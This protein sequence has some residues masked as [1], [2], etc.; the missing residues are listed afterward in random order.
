MSGDAVTIEMSQEG[1]IVLVMPNFCLFYFFLF[2]LVMPIFCFYFSI[3]SRFCSD[4][5][6]DTLNN[7]RP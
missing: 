7:R 5:G 3:L 6:S 1:D 4:A 2:Y